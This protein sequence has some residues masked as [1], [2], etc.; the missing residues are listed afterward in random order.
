[1]KLE[2]SLLMYI[3]NKTN[4]YMKANKD[5]LSLSHRTREPSLI[6]ITFS[7]LIVSNKIKSY[8]KKKHK[9]TKTILNHKN[10]KALSM[11]K[12][13]SHITS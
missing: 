6:K 4:R 13:F 3:I 1:M 7:C 5:P 12:K 2:N 10:K 9:Q 8:E 11:P